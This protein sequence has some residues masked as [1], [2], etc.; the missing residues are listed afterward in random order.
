M[1]DFRLYDY[2]DTQTSVTVIADSTSS[3]TNSRA[4]TMLCR[5]PEIILPN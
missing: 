4:T 3:L 2:L 1:L 5:V